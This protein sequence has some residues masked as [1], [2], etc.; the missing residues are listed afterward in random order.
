[1]TWLALHLREVD[2]AVELRGVADARGITFADAV[3][4]W[5]AGHLW[6]GD[7]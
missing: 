2:L 5:R 1:M 7:D 6:A 4:R 3:S